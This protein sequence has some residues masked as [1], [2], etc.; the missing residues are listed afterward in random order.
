MERILVAVDGSPRSSGVLDAAFDLAVRLEATIVPVTA[1]NVPPE[2]P[3]RHLKSAPDALLV[4]AKDVLRNAL[5]RNPPASVAPPFVRHGAPWRV[6]L[7]AARAFD[8]HTIVIGAHGHGENDPMLGGTASRI[9]GLADRNVLVVRASAPRSRSVIVGLDASD[10]A[11]F[12]FDVATSIAKGA[13]I[14]LVRAVERSSTS[15][16]D[17]ARDARIWSLIAT[18]LSAFARQKPELTFDVPEV[19]MGPAWRALVDRAREIDASLIV[20]GAN[21]SSSMDTLGHTASRV[22]NAADRNVL[23][24]R[25]RPILSTRPPPSS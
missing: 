2:L 18:E 10:E 22:V 1:V 13:S 17:A 25:R 5:P 21:G 23:V 19:R 3:L 4:D 7:D 15:P 20:V 8:A 6:V 11:P 12:L 16:P 9:A 24:V 14:H